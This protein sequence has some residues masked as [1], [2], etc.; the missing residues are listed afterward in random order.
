MKKTLF[1]TIALLVSGSAFATT[2]HY[3]LR[4]GNHVQHLKITETAKEIIVSADVNFEP[5]A[6]EKDQPACSASITD[7]AK[8]MDKDK[9]IL[10]KHSE[11]EATYCELKIRVTETG[12][13]IEQ[14]KDCDNFATGICRFSSDGKEL[15]KVK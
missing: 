7:E 6:N 8:R 5:N 9:L 12:A 14:S 3:V 1:L 15:V 13:K 2:E 11:S 10:K 4:D